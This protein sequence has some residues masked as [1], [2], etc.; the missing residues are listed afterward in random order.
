MLKDG[1]YVGMFHFHFW[2][3]GNWVDVIVDDKLPADTGAQPAFG[4]CSENSEFWLPL[5]E[6]AY[7]K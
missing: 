3:F 5:M 1:G 6:K 2:R 7:A 4:H